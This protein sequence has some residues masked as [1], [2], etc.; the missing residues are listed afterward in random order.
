MAGVV[1]TESD[2]MIAALDLAKQLQV[3]AGELGRVQIVEPA[4]RLDESLWIVG[5][6]S[7]LRIEVG[8]ARRTTLPRRLE[9][10]RHWWQQ[11]LTSELPSA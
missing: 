10:T 3:V 4:A 11:Y 2:R 1:N 8:I 9:E 5:D 6:D 7:H